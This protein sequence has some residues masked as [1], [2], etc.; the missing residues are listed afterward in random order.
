MLIQLLCCKVVTSL[1]SDPEKDTYARPFSHLIPK[2]GIFV[3][4]KWINRN[5]TTN[6]HWTILG[7]NNK[8]FCLSIIYAY[9]HHLWS[10][11]N[12][13]I[14]FSSGEHYGVCRKVMEGEDKNWWLYPAFYA[15]YNFWLFSC[16]KGKGYNSAPTCTCIRDGT[17][18][19]YLSRVGYRERKRRSGPG[20]SRVYPMWVR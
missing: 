9:H 7:I 4:V 11:V 18:R 3:Q 10:L 12:L 5:I 17:Y 6:C 2:V 19:E 15:R 13:W 14:N 8:W 1:T 16:F 20:T